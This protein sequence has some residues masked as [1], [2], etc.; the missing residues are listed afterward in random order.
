MTKIEKYLRKNFTLTEQENQVIP[1]VV[2]EIEQELDDGEYDDNG[3]GQ[4]S[5]ST[6]CDVFNEKMS[7]ALGV[8]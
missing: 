3:M 1:S 7:K 8:A 6:L 5:E 2:A 4:I